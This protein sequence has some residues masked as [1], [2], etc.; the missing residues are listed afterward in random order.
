MY[1]T[2]HNEL[3]DWLQVATSW[4]GARVELQGETS[5]LIV[6][7]RVPSPAL[8]GE[9][10]SRSGSLRL[11]AEQRDVLVAAGW[12]PPEDRECWTRAWR[13]DEDRLGEVAKELEGVGIVV[14]S[15]K[16]V[17]SPEIL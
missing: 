6:R 10:L 11:P 2:T 17:F 16:A 9:I 15:T 12:L 3:F 5:D 14:G 7:L 1:D 8:H 4:P 13:L